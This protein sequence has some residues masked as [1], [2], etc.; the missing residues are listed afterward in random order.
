MFTS[1]DIQNFRLFQDLKLDDLGRI[2]L[3]AGKNNTGKTS[4]LDVIAILNRQYILKDSD[5]LRLQVGTI[6]L[7]FETLFYDFKTTRISVI[8]AKILGYE[9]WFSVFMETGKSR[10]TGGNGHSSDRLTFRY[11]WSMNSNNTQSAEYDTFVNQDNYL[12]HQLITSNMIDEPF[13]HPIE[14]IKNSPLATTV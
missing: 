12:Q 1:L 5:A 11:V 2:N 10:F 7:P 6:A 13:I 4:L 8:H 9:N 3:I 14:Y